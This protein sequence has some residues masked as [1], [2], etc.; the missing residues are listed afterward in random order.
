MPSIARHRRSFSVVERKVIVAR[1]VVCR[2]LRDYESPECGLRPQ[3]HASV[4]S[5]R[6][7]PS[8][9]VDFGPLADVLRQLQWWLGA[10]Y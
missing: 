3:H 7:A 9:E 2:S 5:V 10:H 1:C 4:L 8:L 6:S